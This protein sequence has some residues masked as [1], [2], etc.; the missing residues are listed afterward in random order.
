MNEMEAARIFAS[1]GGRARA[2]KLS[3]KRRVEI[4]RQGGRAKAANAIIKI[5]SARCRSYRKRDW[6]NDSLVF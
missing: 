3:K 2:R 1:M 4:A 5:V 6:Q